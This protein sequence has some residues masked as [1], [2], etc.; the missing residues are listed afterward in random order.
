MK[1]ESMTSSNGNV[2]PNQFVMHGDDGSSVFQS[3]N[4]VIAKRDN[5]GIL[6]LDENFWDYSVTTSKYRNQFTGMNTKETKELLTSGVIGLA[7]LN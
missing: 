4:S 6:T 1:V 5:G 7:N 2:V 3:Y